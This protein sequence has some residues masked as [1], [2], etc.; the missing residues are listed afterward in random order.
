MDFD[1]AVEQIKLVGHEQGYE[2]SEGSRTFEIFID[3][4]H[5][6]AYKIIANSSS[7]YIQVHQWEAG[8][9]DSEGQYGRGV[10]SLRNYSDVA[11]FCNILVASA[12]IRARRKD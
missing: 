7:G 3:N 4:H 2:M 6:V 5:A 9:A 11:H 1:F 10:Y 8:D 12:Y